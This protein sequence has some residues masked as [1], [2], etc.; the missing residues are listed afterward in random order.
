MHKSNI[1]RW[2]KVLT[3][4]GA[5]SLI[6]GFTNAPQVFAQSTLPTPT[7]NVSKTSCSIT[8]NYSGDYYYWPVPTDV[9]A[10]SM[11]VIGAQGGRNGG[12]G[13]KLLGKFST[14]PTGGLY[15]FV[16]GQGASGNGAAGG[17]NGGGAAGRGHGD[18]GS[19]GGASDIRTSLALSDRIAV[20]AGGGGT[21]GWVGGAGG[22]GGNVGGSGGAG[23]GGAGL[24]A[25][26]TAG[27][28]GGAAFG[29]LAS[30]GSAG[31]SGLGGA[32]GSATNPGS[33]VAG[34]G[35]GGG[36]YFGG[37]GGGADTDP[38][39]LDGGGGGG[40][41]D[42]VNTS[43][44]NSVT[45][46][47]GFQPGDGSVT[48]TYS[49]SPD[50]LSFTAPVSPS[51]AVT[52]TFSITFGQSVTGFTAD[53]M[54]LLGTATGC[55]VS[56][57]SG[58]AASYVVTVSGCTDG[59]LQVQL[60]PDTVIGSA[61]G[62]VR[63]VSTALITLDR[64]TPEVN[65]ITKASSANNLAVFRVN[66]TE[67]VTGLAGDNSDWLVK[68][69]GCAISSL[70]GNSADY[71][72]TV[73][74]CMDGRFAALVLNQNAVADAAGNLGPTVLGQ[75]PTV[76]IDNTGP[77]MRITDVTSSEVGAP[78]T[79]VIDSDEPTTGLSAAKFS[80]AGTSTSCVL[81]LSELR[82]GLGWRAVLSGC[83]PGTAGIVLAA[84]ATADLTG[85][86]G[87]ATAVAS[88]LVVVAA[89]ATVNQS[90][91]APSGSGG[92]GFSHQGGGSTGGSQSAGGNSHSASGNSQGG[93]SQGGN[94]A[95][96]G[97]PGNDAGGSSGADSANGQPSDATAGGDSANDQSRNGTVSPWHPSVQSKARAGL[98][99]L[100]ATTER[101]ALFGLGLAMLIA[102]LLTAVGKPKTRAKLAASK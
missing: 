44:I 15:I 51:N 93:N 74:N 27:G 13:A 8:F 72:I 55:Y 36:G 78:P 22:T 45:H 81:A 68:G 60:N 23:Q 18:E 33:T 56:N 50:V 5:I 41:S 2:P 66:F 21:G 98:T 77:G 99:W 90:V 42:F 17:F 47:I 85:N 59:T 86:L 32:G 12:Y 7:C 35:G 24:G 83:K 97:N 6:L 67:P 62:P 31:A 96:G 92:T 10:I 46:Y 29:A 26:A 95:V 69:D 100:N 19:G 75:S 57:L 39:G 84:N 37:G 80:I 76:R 53:D 65:T 101:N 61:P 4:I 9:R 25:S 87:P 30:A 58:S 102:A 49:F 48:L 20:A 82:A 40:G 43:K 71:V 88:N 38:A 54:T 3:S 34:G 70:T 94:A 64:A 52:P 79:F 14:L 16:G 63:A 91:T 1:R 11:S 73:S 28:A 89:D